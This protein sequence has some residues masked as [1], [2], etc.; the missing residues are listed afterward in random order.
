MIKKFS[1]LVI[2]N[3]SESYLVYDDDIKDG[4]DIYPNSAIGRKKLL[5]YLQYLLYNEEDF[6]DDDDEDDE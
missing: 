1:K 3:G 5:Q 4:I 2:K 6:D